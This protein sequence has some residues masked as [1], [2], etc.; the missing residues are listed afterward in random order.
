M[1][2]TH[3]EALQGTP[4]PD[5][6]TYQPLTLKHKNATL[7]PCEYRPHAFEARVGTRT[8]D[9]PIGTHAPVI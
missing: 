3:E 7:S 9:L 8:N 5:G 4:Q 6:I 1:I 2:V